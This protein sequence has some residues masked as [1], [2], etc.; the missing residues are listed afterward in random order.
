MYKDELIKRYMYLY[1]NKELIL[2][3]CINVGIEEDRLN[4]QIKNSKNLLK[5]N[6]IMKENADLCDIFKQKIKDYSLELK[7]GKYYLM[8]NVSNEIVSMFEE[9]LFS[10]NNMESLNLYKHIEAVKCSEEYFD[11][12]NYLIESFKKIR[13]SYIPLKK[14]PTFSVWKILSYVQRKNKDNIIIEKALDKYYNLDRYVSYLDDSKD[15]YY[16]KE[17]DYIEEEVYY[18]YPNSIIMN[19]GIIIWPDENCFEIEDEYFD[20]LSER[21]SL[22]DSCFG[23]SDFMMALSNMEMLD[24]ETKV[25]VREEL[26]KSH[27]L[28]KVK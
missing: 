13:K 18:K 14:L 1:Q 12:I 11:S 10:D 5:K 23:A 4:K 9:F 27:T 15:G 25:S 7:Y 21:E 24:L 16:I 26:L 17:I 3:L 2:A 28:I 20:V 22:E 19:A 8:G 6:K